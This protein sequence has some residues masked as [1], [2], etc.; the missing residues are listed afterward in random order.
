MS[1]KEI[2]SSYAFDYKGSGGP[3]F[4]SEEAVLDFIDNDL[5]QGIKSRDPKEF[6]V[7][8]HLNGMALMASKT[9]SETGEKTYLNWSETAIVRFPEGGI[10]W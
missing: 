7:Q 3:T 4:S 2:T 8:M 6:E 10:P 1:D 9:D 5:L